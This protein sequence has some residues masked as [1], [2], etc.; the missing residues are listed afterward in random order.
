[1][2]FSIAGS[3]A[4]GYLASRLPLLPAL[5]ITATLR[6]L[7]LAGLWWLAQADATARGVIAFTC[8]ENFFGGAL[9]TALFAFMMS[10][11]DRKI[12]ATHYTLLAA[13]EV[14]GKL[15]SQGVSGWIADQTSYVFVF[16]LAVGLS[17]AFLALLPTLKRTTR[18]G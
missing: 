9:T 3:T 12:G 1:M 4:G 5:S 16:G 14:W 18:P 8:A 6:V 2:L 17:A 15:A 10:R 13:L 11:I 7:P